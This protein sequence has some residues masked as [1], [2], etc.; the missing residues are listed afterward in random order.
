MGA[1]PPVIT[2]TGTSGTSSAKGTPTVLK[3]R[4]KQALSSK[5]PISLTKSDM[6]ILMKE[7]PSEVTHG[8]TLL[9]EAFEEFDDIIGYKCT[10]A[11]KEVDAH[12]VVKTIILD[13]YFKSNCTSVQSKSSEII[14]LLS[15]SQY[16]KAFAEKMKNILVKF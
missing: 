10:L 9:E 6:N 5:T 13:E 14:K 11:G 4:I 3:D 16:P 12:D 2:I 7:F 15:Q 1:S 8:E